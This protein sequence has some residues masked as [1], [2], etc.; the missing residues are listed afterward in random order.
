VDTAPA[1][2]QPGIVG[3]VGFAG[4]VGFVGAGGVGFV[5]FVV[6]VGGV[7]LLSE[8]HAATRGEKTS[9]TVAPAAAFTAVHKNCLRFCMRPSIVEW[10]PAAEAF[11]VPPPLLDRDDATRVAARAGMVC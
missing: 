3:S 1:P 11:S 5:G 4:G 9:V 7:G 6:V 10:T 2:S 8:P